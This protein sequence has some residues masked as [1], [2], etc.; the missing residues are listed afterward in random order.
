MHIFIDTFLIKSIS[1]G[2]SENRKNLVILWLAQYVRQAGDFGLPPCRAGILRSVEWYFVTDNWEQLIGPFFKGLRIVWPW[3][4]GPIVYPE[5]SVKNY[6]T[7]L[8]KI[9]E[10]RRS[11]SLP[12]FCMWMS[13]CQILMRSF[14]LFFFFKSHLGILRFSVMY[15]LPK[16]QIPYSCI[17]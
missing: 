16:L 3:K 10:E 2:V 17:L 13:G 15:L 7:R 14:L 6:Q 4:E 9:P 11:L 8:R 1:C 5:T 12:P